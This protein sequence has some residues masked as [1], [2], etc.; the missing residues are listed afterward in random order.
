MQHVPG[1]AELLPVSGRPLAIGR[2]PGY[3]VAQ[4]GHVDA[5][6]MGASG[7]QRNLDEGA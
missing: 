7:L 2:I 5:N 4:M 6:L 1:D 3:R